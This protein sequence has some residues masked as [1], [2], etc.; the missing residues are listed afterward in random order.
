MLNGFTV[1]EISRVFDLSPP[2]PPKR[3]KEARLKLHGQAIRWDGVKE[4]SIGAK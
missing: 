2:P 4:I 3:S 1:L